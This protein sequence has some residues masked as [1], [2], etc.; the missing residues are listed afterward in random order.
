MKIDEDGLARVPP[1]PSWEPE[2]QRELL[3]GIVDIESR[4]TLANLLCW[5]IVAATAFTMPNAE[6][7][8]I[9]LA[10]RVAAMVTTRS[11]FSMLRRRL[12]DRSHELPSLTLLLAAL[13]FGGI[14]WGAT[15]I[16]VVT[17]P[18]LHPG[19]LLIGG[20]TIAGM[21]IIVSLLLPAPRLALAYMAGFASSFGAALQWAPTDFAMDAGMGIVG[22]FAIFMAYGYA[23]VGRSR[24]TA[25][26]LVENRRLSEDLSTALA[27]AEFLAYRDPLTGLANRR[28]FFQD[29]DFQNEEAAPQDTTRYILLIDLDHFK[30][31]ND[32]N[33]HD[34]GDKVLVGVAE[35]SKAALAATGQGDACIARLGGEEFG[36]IL[37]RADRNLA[38]LTA[39][40]LRHAISLVPKR[41]GL[42]NVVV[43]ASI[44][45]CECVA[46]ETLGEAMCRAD[47]AM[48][49]A[50]DRGRN[51]VERGA[52][53]A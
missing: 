43:T 45:V 34:V 21:S 49:R 47:S 11:T 30:S 14:A 27:N 2:I 53:A 22:L 12:A 13:F 8:T 9:P 37:D 29:E 4:A 40:M 16:P 38:Y 36:V 50:K 1:D 35:V 24:K 28:A 33:G 17:D 32:T 42:E 20:A 48:Y 3:K 15:L 10:L 23:T 25:E 26:T 5:A 41:I 39:E 52:A 18:F 44:G 31:I 6:M 51:R 46:G 19:R 7:Y